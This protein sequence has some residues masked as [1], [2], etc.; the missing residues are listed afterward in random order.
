MGA[1]VKASLLMLSQTFAVLADYC[2][3]EWQIVRYR[4]YY[5]KQQLADTSERIVSDAICLVFSLLVLATPCSG[6]NSQKMSFRA[7]TKEARRLEIMFHRW[8]IVLCRVYRRQIRRHVVSIVLV[9][10]AGVSVG[11]VFCPDIL[12]HQ[13][14]HA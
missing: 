10:Y 8:R 6:G 14:V 12:V 4:G 2:F 9:L 5:V 13:Q 7:R 3:F 11:A 1:K